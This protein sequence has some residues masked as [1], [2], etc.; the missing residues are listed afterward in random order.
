M[1]PNCLGV[2][3]FD[4][5]SAHVAYG[6]PALHVQDMNLNPGGKQAHLRKT[7]V[8]TDDPGIPFTTNQVLYSLE[9]GPD[10]NG[11]K[12]VDNEWI[13]LCFCC[14]SVYPPPPYRRIFP[15]G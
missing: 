2:W 11:D 15:V 3:I 13:I 7:D 8:P 1:H 12:V 14:E 4:C 9:V 6:P 5:S 10:R